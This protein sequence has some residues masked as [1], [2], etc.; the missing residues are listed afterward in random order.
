[1]A[2]KG[3]KKAKSGRKPRA[4]APKREVVVPQTPLVSKRWFQISAAALATLLLGLGLGYGFG[5]QA[6]EDDERSAD[7]ARVKSIEAIDAAATGALKGTGTMDGA[8]FAPFPELAAAMEDGDTGAG[9]KAAKDAKQAAESLTQ[10][11]LEPISGGLSADEVAQV[12]E[13]FG[14]LIQGMELFRQA[15]DTLAS[16]GGDP[17][18]IA[19]ARDL[20]AS[21][22][23]VSRF[24]Y[25]EIAR[26]KVDAGLIEPPLDPQQMAEQAAQQGIP[27]QIPEGVPVPTQ[28]AGQPPAGP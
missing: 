26:L 27:G 20:A 24:A 23:A 10:V 12:Q 5:N 13:S 6:A 14:L 19:Q 11:Q 28:P 17:K 25:Q 8:T 21:A 1:M 4:A 9:S 3:K 7:A 16:S 2:I 18:Q 22:D 15:G